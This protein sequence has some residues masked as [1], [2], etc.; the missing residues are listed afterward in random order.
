[1]IIYRTW[2]ICFLISGEIFAYPGQLDPTFGRN[3]TVVTHFDEKYNV[4]YSLALQDEGKIIVAGVV[5]NLYPKPGACMALACYI[6]EGTLDTSFGSSGLVKT[7]FGPNFVSSIVNNVMVTRDRKIVVT[8]SVFDTAGK[9]H[10]ALARYD[11][12]GVLDTSFNQHGD[13]PGTVVTSF[14][15]WQDDDCIAYGS[16]LQNDGKIIVVGQAAFWEN[17]PY[18]LALARYTIDGT[19]DTSF[20][21]SGPQ[22]G[23]LVT[24]FGYSFA[25]E[26]FDV[27]IDDD[28]KVLVVGDWNKNFII[29]RYTKEGLL[30]TSF[31]PEGEKPGAILMTFGGSEDL[32]RKLIEQGDGTFI[33]MGVTNAEGA[34]AF[35]LARFHNNGTLDTSFNPY[36]KPPA[37]P[38]I[39]ISQISKIAAAAKALRVQ[40]GDK[41]LVGGNALFPLNSSEFVLV[42]Y[43]TN[44]TLDTSFSPAGNGIVRTSFDGN[45]Y[46]TDIA[47]QKDGKIVA[48]GVVVYKNNTSC[49]ALAR[50]MN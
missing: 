6:H 42:R 9:N 46:L 29:A 40:A 14:G 19:L 26:A 11:A 27:V 49:F 3:G 50:Y 30:D 33:V 43:N 31:N 47:I 22:P 4:A 18:Q 8:G 37:W 10:F 2:L 41:I 36:A 20:N 1:M 48:A 45:S 21:C 15:G 12:H 16:I 5:D 17:A 35:A 38:G 13:V 39:V 25:A 23:T 7:F 24:R 34:E 44:G 32:A 28:Q